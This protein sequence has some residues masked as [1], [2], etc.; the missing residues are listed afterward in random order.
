[1]IL[2]PREVLALLLEDYGNPLERTH[3]KSDMKRYLR[4]IRQDLIDYGNL[5][6]KQFRSLKQYLIFEFKRDWKEIRQKFSDCIRKG[7][8]K[9]RSPWK[10]KLIEDV[11]GDE[12][13]PNTLEPFIEKD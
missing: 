4:S 12:D 6:E 13:C 9:R 1:M 3:I 7:K 5:S 10:P 8:V 11:F 2:E